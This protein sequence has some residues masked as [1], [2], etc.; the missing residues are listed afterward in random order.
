MTERVFVV[1]EYDGETGRSVFRGIF[2]TKEAAENFVSSAR[3]QK[4]CYSIEEYA[5]NNDGT[6]REIV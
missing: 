3:R 2:F 5:P 1:V 6:A 4:E